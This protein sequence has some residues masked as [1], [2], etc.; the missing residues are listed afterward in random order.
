[1]AERNLLEQK[2]ADELQTLGFGIQGQTL[3]I[4]QLPP[5]TDAGIFLVAAASPPP[6]E[7]LDTE[8]HVVDV[9]I[10]SDYTDYAYKTLQA[11]YN[12]YHR[13][14]NYPLGDWYIYFSEALTTPQDMNRDL[15]SGKLFKLSVQFECRNTNNVS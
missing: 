1:M 2:I 5:D 6:H 12:A 15:E 8:F 11:V 10:R 14:S 7:Y 4:G 3:F 9:W 13:R